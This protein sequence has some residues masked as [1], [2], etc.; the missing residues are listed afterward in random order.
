MDLFDHASEDDSA[1]S[2]RP[3]AIRM[4]PRTLDEYVGQEH[5]VGPGKLLRRLLEANRIVS[6]ILYGPPGTGKTG[7]ARLVARRNKGRFVALN[8]V[9][10]GLADLRK[11]FD[12][13]QETKKLYQRTTILFLDEI[14]HFNKSQQD[15][16]LPHLEQGTILLV[17]ATTQNPFFALNS[18]L[19]SRSRVCELRLLDEKD[20]GTIL[21]RAL[22]D[23]DRGLGN[24]QVDL[25]PDART[26]LLK[27]S[28]GDGRTL[29]NAL[30]VGVLTTPPDA[31]GTIVLTL[32]V[33]QESIQKKM[34]QYDASGDQ[35]YDTISAFIKSIRGS[36]PDASLYWLA[37]MLYAG[38]DPRF[39][40]RRLVISAA[41]DVG[42]ADP[43]ALPLA[44]AAQQALEFIGLPEGRIPLA[45]ATVY[46][47]CA[48]KSNAA[49]KGL[50]GATEDVKKESTK[51]VPLHLKDGHYPGAKVLGHG[52]GYQYAHDHPDHYVK[53]EYAPNPGRYY[54][55]T[56]LG[57]EAKI[58]AWLEHLA[59]LDKGSQ[60]P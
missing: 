45:Q 3:L 18:A 35:H 53:Q 60:Q 23:K 58:K 6:L 42:N 56:T 49:Y 51:E 46:L 17:G 31:Q 20:L 30:E 5:L 16:L 1:L 34:V 48:P 8:A 24:Y 7:F 47:A 26:H 11:V 37:K 57:H 40:A 59:E 2:G 19:L 50:E 28:S 13:A 44:V 43:Q 36:D 41:E 55:P 39:I 25:R 15:A 29:L 32:E 21:D 4:S 12:E 14:H 33:A 54:L 22:A 52:Q 27:A 38:E 9:T 10:S